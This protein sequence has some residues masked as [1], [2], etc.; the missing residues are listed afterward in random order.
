MKTLAAL[1][2]RMSPRIPQGRARVLATLPRPSTTPLRRMRTPG[3]VACTARTARHPVESHLA[4][5][6]QSGGGAKRNSRVTS[7][8]GGMT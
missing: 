1:E 7:S 5:R 8:Q 3:Y 2:S 6:R 4:Q